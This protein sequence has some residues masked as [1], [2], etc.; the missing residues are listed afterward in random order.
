M[1]IASD[2]TVGLPVI[3]MGKQA[4]I[5]RAS[6][7]GI[8]AE[9]LLPIGTGDSRHETWAVPAVN[10]TRVV[11]YD[12]HRDFVENRSVLCDDCGARVRPRTLESLPEHGCAERQRARRATSQ[13]EEGSTDG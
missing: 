3:I 12:V 7:V 2:F 9:S 6:S 8:Y 1:L 10:V 13:T 5:T 11:V 4:D